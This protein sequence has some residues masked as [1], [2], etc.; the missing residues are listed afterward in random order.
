MAHL[1]RTAPALVPFHVRARVFRGLCQED[2][3]AHGRLS[4]EMVASLL[5]GESGLR[6]RRDELFQDGFDRIGQMTAAEL[7]GQI[8]IVFVNAY[9]AEEAGVDGGGLFKDFLVRSRRR[10]C[11]LALFPCLRRCALNPAKRR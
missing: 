5:R 8:R 6:V 3:E 4:R 7:K 1:L 2:R 11:P 10:A 9:G